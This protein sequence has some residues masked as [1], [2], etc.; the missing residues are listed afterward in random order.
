MH[1]ITA[2]LSSTLS[3]SGITF[4]VEGVDYTTIVLSSNGW[5]E[6]G[7]N[8]SGNS[9]PSND[10]LPTAAHTNPFVAMYWDDLNPFG[11]S[12]RHGTVGSAG[13]RVFIADYE[14]DLNVGE[15]GDDIRFQVQLHER[16]NTITVRYRDS[17][18][19]AN[20]QGATIGFQGA[21]GASATTV[22]PLGCNGKIL[23]DNRPDEGWSADVGRAG[24]PARTRLFRWQVVW[25]N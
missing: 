25:E 6:F 12:V 24:L 14:V 20:G 3:H 1:R 13:N 23:D 8:T 5:I 11:T 21:G 9:D 22:Q 16:S 2:P 10:C 18:D 15:G 7:S 19:V 17:Q 4:T